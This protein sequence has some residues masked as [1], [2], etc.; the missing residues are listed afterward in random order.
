MELD[1]GTTNGRPFVAVTAFEPASYM[2]VSFTVVKTQSLRILAADPVSE[3]GDAIAVTG[4]VVDADAERN[5]IAL[6]PVIVRHKDRLSP[7]VGKEL[8]CEVDAG[9]TFY[10][11]TGGKRIV[12]LTYRDRDLLR[13][14][15]KILRERGKQGWADFLEQELAKRRKAR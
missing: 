4:K 12:S 10:S 3:P 14:K 15:D 5:A 13:F 2:D 11:Y 9:A 7:A 6:D 8:L 1:R